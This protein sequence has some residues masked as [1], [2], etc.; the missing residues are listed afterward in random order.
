M[1]TLIKLALL[2]AVLA[3][4]LGAQ[5]GAPPPA[6]GSGVSVD[7]PS[8]GMHYGASHSFLFC[9]PAGWT[10]DNSTDY[11]PGVFA[12]LYPD[13]SSWDSAKQTGTLMYITTF[14]K[15]NDKYTVEKAMAFDAH[16]TKKSSKFAGLVVK[17]GEPIKLDD[18][19]A[20]VQLFAP[21][22]FNRYEACAYIDSP[23]TIIEFVITSK[24]EDAFNRDYPAFVQF[25][26]SY[27]FLSSNVTVQYK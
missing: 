21:G 9:A 16:D 18:L 25:V 13:G 26:Q 4:Q 15:P 10:L 12:T 7:K 5:T 11:L 17:K 3:V 19:A 22:P 24:D 1:K 14:D 8:C 23:K 2:L 27:K 6:Q 20:P